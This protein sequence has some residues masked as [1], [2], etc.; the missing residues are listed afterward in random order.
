MKGWKYLFKEREYYF[1][2][3]TDV[4][5]ALLNYAKPGWIAY[6]LIPPID[7]GK[8]IELVIGMAIIGCAY[9]LIMGFQS[10]RNNKFNTNIEISI[11]ADTFSQLMKVPTQKI[12]QADN[13]TVETIINNS[14]KA[15][16]RIKL[17]ITQVVYTA[18]GFTG[19]FIVILTQSRF[20]ALLSFMLI[21]LAV[22]INYKANKREQQLFNNYVD[23]EKRHD[24]FINN[25]YNNILTIM[26][27]EKGAFFNN[28]EKS[29]IISLFKKEE[30]ELKF[31]FTKRL[32]LG[33]L[34]NL[35]LIVLVV[36]AIIRLKN[37]DASAAGYIIF[38]LGTVDRIRMEIE[39]SQDIMTA[40]IEQKKANEDIDDF[41]KDNEEKKVSPKTWNTFAINSLS[42]SYQ[43]SANSIYVPL[44]D[45]K[46][47][48]IV[49][50]MGESGQGKSTFLSIL[51]GYLKKNMGKI[52][53]DGKSWFYGI[54]NSEYVSQTMALFNISLWDNICLGADIPKEKVDYLFEKAGLKEWLDS[55]PEGYETKIADD[56]ANISDGQK[57]RIKFI[58]ALL[59]DKST[60]L[61]D[62]PTANLDNG[63]KELIVKMINE[64][65]KDKT[66]IISTHDQE[67][68]K[69]C[70]R[71]YYF[72]EGTL[73]ELQQ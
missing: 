39:R 3:M 50:I 34:M 21:S 29:S 65:L 40:V 73:H 25:L 38:Y 10:V 23:E 45:I 13:G 33:L 72:S 30:E 42:F 47:G 41:F 59:R 61:L 43:S 26:K 55:L 24:G 63:S 31:F 5:T 22:F 14:I 6:C 52:T 53:L 27:L 49:S 64:F 48:E 69:I 9:D 20:I 46:K 35:Y 68:T 32:A 2:L 62:E 12:I 71:H 15:V 17:F 66:I 18:I 57:M 56:A 7:A 70:T 36:D 51:A 19:L 1:L 4:I 58:R 67:I 60:Y 54:P 16:T 11:K 37:G 44:F 28:L 8:M